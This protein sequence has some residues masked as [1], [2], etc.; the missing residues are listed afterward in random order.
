MMITNGAGHD[1]QTQAALRH[2]EGTQ[3]RGRDHAGAAPGRAALTLPTDDGPQ[4]ESKESPG[5]AAASSNPGE[6]A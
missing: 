1:R 3:Q 6:S 2:Q 5:R 4:S